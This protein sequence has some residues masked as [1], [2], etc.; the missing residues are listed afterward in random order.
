MRRVTL[1]FLGVFGIGSLSGASA[2]DVA[3]RPA[4][5]APYAMYNWTGF[6][7]G[8]H[9]GYAFGRKDWFDDNGASETGSHDV[10]GMIAGGQFGFNW[11]IRS[12]VLGI[13]GDASWANVNGGH[14]WE[15]GGFTVGT[16]V[17]WLGTIGG[18]LG[19]AFDRVLFYAKGGAAF[20][21]DEHSFVEGLASAEGEKTRWGW[22]I[23]GGVEAA[24]VGNW[25][26]KGE[27]S[28]MD[29]GKQAV[30]FTGQSGPAFTS[31]IE[32][33]LHLIK[34]GLNYRFGP[35]SVVARY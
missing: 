33:E 9:V 2:A 7:L 6:Y 30:A 29:F 8:A 26:I 4:V 24:W 17:R 10:S 1:A 27:Y 3:V 25:S 19:Y 35:T 28:Y 5:E 31:H 12:V 20:A 23:G 15:E 34:V 13:E 32:Q 21:H 16:D 11:Q 14:F 22:M 18:R